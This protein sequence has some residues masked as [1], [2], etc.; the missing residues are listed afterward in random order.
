[1]SRTAHRCS[2]TTQ[3]CADTGQQFA[4]P[5]R[6]GDVIA[7]AGLKA[8]DNILL[9]IPTG[10][11]DDR[12]AV[13]K[14]AQLCTEVEPIAV[15]QPHVQDHRIEA[16]LFGDQIGAGFLQGGGTDSCEAT[17]NREMRRE[18]SLNATSSSTIRIGRSVDMPGLPAGDC[19]CA[20]AA[21]R[22]RWSIL[23]SSN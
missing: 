18:I 8:A 20:N 5:E 1:M 22:L 17:A 12:H 21:F 11:H 6:L 14:L 10:Q 7:G 15:R 16:L 19:R 2:Q 13:A 4:G 3:L 23:R 9:G